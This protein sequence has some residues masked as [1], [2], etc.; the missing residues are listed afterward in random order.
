[1]FVVTFHG[2][3]SGTQQ[4]YSYD[5]DG[6]GGVPYLTAAT[7]SGTTGFRD[8]QFLPASTAGFFYLVNSYK[9]S[10]DVFQISPQATAVPAPPVFILWEDDAWVTAAA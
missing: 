6:R 9:N 7:P 4:L 10:S 5:D 1:M 8:I 2:G 3:I